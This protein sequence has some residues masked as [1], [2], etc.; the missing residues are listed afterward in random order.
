MDLTPDF[1][2]LKD[3]FDLEREYIIPRF[4]R[5]YSWESDEL[6]TLW[7]DLID[8]IQINEK[9]ELIV[10]EYFFGSVVFSKHDKYPKSRMRYIVDGQ[11]RLTTIT[12]IFSVIIKIFDKYGK[13]KL[14]D[15]MYKS[16]LDIDSNLGEY[17]KLRTETS[18]PYFQ[19]RIQKRKIDYI[20]T[21]SPEEDLINN[22]FHFFE[23]KLS[24]KNLK[25]EFYKYF[26]N[27]ENIDELYIELIKKIR[28]QVFAFKL[29]KMTEE[30]YEDAY[31]LFEVLNAK[32]KSLSAVDII[33]NRIFTVCS[34]TEPSDFA[35]DTWE[36][37]SDNI[38]TSPEKINKL[39]T[40][41]RHFWISKYSFSTKKNLV[42]E[43]ARN[44][45]KNI[46]S[47]EK[48][49]TEMKGSS[50]IYNNIFN[51]NPVNYSDH[52]KKFEYISLNAISKVFKV[53][54]PRIILLSLME[55]NDNGKIKF[56]DYK[57]TIIF[58]ERFHFIFSRI[59][60]GRGSKYESLYARTARNLRN[61]SD[62]SESK[63]T[64]NEFMLEVDEMTPKF[65][66]YFPYFMELQYD[67]DKI[68]IQYIFRTIEKY[69]R[70]TDEIE[71]A[72]L[73]LEHLNSQESN[74]L[75]IHKIG[76]LIP[77]EGHINENCDNKD[78]YEKLPLYENSNYLSVKDFLGN[79]DNN[80][81][82]WTEN[83]IDERTKKIAKLM[84]TDVWKYD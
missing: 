65:E 78:F 54:Q 35:K 27:Q 83:D 38:N 58:L 25:V 76:N 8:A 7:N 28:D 57:K 32:G 50:L 34:N 80:K 22:S 39:E 5:A 16:I 33:K 1:I 77:L 44:I 73:T 18:Y 81:K 84:Y 82:E 29:M 21:S 23:K 60:S 36:N 41:Y 61:C 26:E 51:P 63:K 9:K 20:D 17:S 69:Y 42:R 66:E 15:Y 79:I 45:P 48:F 52:A 47:Y 2:T 40:F 30:N 68:V 53:T 55:C 12:I 11:Q 70:K 14:A 75:N 3:M 19:N 10:S 49:L 59:T 43:F 72:S 37:I 6:N 71:T 62:R 31:M 24:P 56:S 46:R 4:Q 74:S 13:E 67:D 64:L